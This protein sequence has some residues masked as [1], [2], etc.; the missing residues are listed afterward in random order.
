MHGSA[1]FCLS[2]LSLALLYWVISR[3]LAR[4]LFTEVSRIQP[5]DSPTLLFK[6]IVYSRS[7][8][9]KLVNRPKS[10][11]RFETP[12]PRRVT[13]YTSAWFH[14]L[15][16]ALRLMRISYAGIPSDTRQCQVMT[17][18]QS[19]TDRIGHCCT[20]SRKWI[21][22]FRALLLWGLVSWLNIYIS[23][24]YIYIYT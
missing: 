8:V 1:M 20:T 16:H 7:W 17:S 23:N 9:R 4:L 19:A 13:S 10:V 24:R 5:D 21:A 22:A 18:M 12:I 6:A 15:P 3:Y 2:W 14:W 11:N